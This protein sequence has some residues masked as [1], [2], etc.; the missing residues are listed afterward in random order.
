MQDGAL[1]ACADGHEATA[2]RV[3][4]RQEPISHARTGTTLEE[5]VKH[6]L[7]VCPSIP[8]VATYVTSARRAASG[9]SVKSGLMLRYVGSSVRCIS[10]GRL[11]LSLT[12]IAT[13]ELD[14]HASSAVL[15]WAEAAS[16]AR[17]QMHRY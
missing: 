6:A 4:K 8:Y 9:A 12:P 5:Q 10:T 13:G 11:A 14:A 2:T 3:D 17:G 16:H 7:T 15:V 1:N